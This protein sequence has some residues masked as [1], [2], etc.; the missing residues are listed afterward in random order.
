MGRKKNTIE[1]LKKRILVDNDTGCWVWQGTLN[2]T[3][4]AIGKYQDR[5]QLMHRVFFA[6]DYG[7]VLSSCEQLDHLCRNR[8]C[9]N[10]Q[11]LEIVSG[12]E[13]SRRSRNTKLNKEEVLD[14][15]RRYVAG[16]VTQQNLADEHCVTVRTINGIIQGRD[17]ITDMPHYEKQSFA[18]RRS[19]LNMKLTDEDVATIRRR[20][21]SEDVTFTQ[22]GKEYGIHPSYIGRIVRGLFR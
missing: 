1:H 2:R 5:T 6:D 11:H 19:E 13:N 10:P 18:H 3:G 16:G 15:R 9:V 17:W 21:A 14:I 22:L 7:N 12:A 8:A 4:Y 20:H